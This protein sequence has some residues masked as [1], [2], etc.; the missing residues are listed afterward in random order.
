MAE[1]ERCTAARTQAIG[2]PWRRGAR[3]C[4]NKARSSKAEEALLA[5]IAA[6]PGRRLGAP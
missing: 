4:L 6:S 5:L 2:P 3:S 1:I